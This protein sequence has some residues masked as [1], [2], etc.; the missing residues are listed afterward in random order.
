[1]P[2]TTDNDSELLL[3]VPG[4]PNPPHFVVDFPGYVR[5]EQR[6]L[7]T[8]GG[9]KGLERQIDSHPKHL[10]LKLRHGDPHSHPI[11][12]DARR[13]ATCIVVELTRTQQS[14]EN[15]F[16]SDAVSAR[17]LGVAESRYGF[18][19]PADFQYAGRDPRPPR[20]QWACQADL[21]DGSPDFLA[22][23][24]LLCSPP[25]GAVEGP[26]EY[27]FRQY[28]ARDHGI[29][30]ALG[31]NP[32]G[33]KKALGTIWVDYFAVKVPQSMEMS[34]EEEATSTSNKIE[35][36]VGKLKELLARRPIYLEAALGEA[37][38]TLDRPTNQVNAESL[39]ATSSTPAASFPNTRS[40]MDA[41]NRCCY[42]F[43][44]GPWKGAWVR[45]GFDPRVDASARQYQVL[46]Y[47]MPA[48]WYKKLLKRGH[49]GS[50]LDSMGRPAALS[51]TGLCT[52]KGVPSTPSVAMQL[53]DV[54]DDTVRQAISDDSSACLAARANDA[55]GWLMQSAWEGIKSRVAARF[56]LVLEAAGE[57]RSGF[58][59]QGERR[60]EDAESGF[61]VLP[62]SLLSD[63]QQFLSMADGQGHGTVGGLSKA[64]QGIIAKRPEVAVS[65]EKTDVID[66]DDEEDEDEE[67][68]D[69]QE[70]VDGDDD[71]DVD[72]QD[73][74][75]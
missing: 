1:M 62:P 19:S 53:C 4:G 51:Y 24:P 50:I 69:P 61:A 10:Q 47:S 22:Q 37:M 74:R 5:N 12:S 16:S 73:V 75:L 20:E 15:K 14:N 57:S 48:D 52:F 33:A 54:E 45:K 7:A 43:R 9:I 8:F 17:V 46:E 31:P 25:T 38:D 67:V 44:N 3:N 27:A 72:A 28:H 18:S 55:S 40:H 30:T 13:S 49:G 59:T 41:L 68:E 71:D 65:N 70:E 23:S 34:G 11:V 35:T 39:S 2:S 36:M 56:Q 63:L 21:A 58:T 66:L 60:H 64:P 6:A 32:R 26:I 29:K 42:R